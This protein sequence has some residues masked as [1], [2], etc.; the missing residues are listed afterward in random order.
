MPDASSSCHVFLEWCSNLNV[1]AISFL[2]FQLILDRV[3]CVTIAG[4]FYHFV[5]NSHN[6]KIKRG[7][8]EHV[9]VLKE[10]KNNCLVKC[11]HC[12]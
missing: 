9:S 10:T 4:S 7:K 2:Y 11:V 12:C 1:A 5:V 3:S 6:D 8:W